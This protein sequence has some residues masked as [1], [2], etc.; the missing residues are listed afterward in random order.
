[1]NEREVSSTCIVPRVWQVIAEWLK[2]RNLKIWHCDIV[3]AKVVNT[4][5]S[6][7]RLTPHPKK[8]E[9][10]SILEKTEGGKKRKENEKW[11]NVD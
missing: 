8:V 4:D 9:S 11:L 5:F 6:Q 1:M 10:Y 2:Q 3:N 7:K